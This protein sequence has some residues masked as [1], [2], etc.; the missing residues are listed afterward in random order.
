[1][2]GDGVVV[3]LHDPFLSP[4]ITRDAAGRWL[5]GKG[6]PVRSLTLAQLQAHD[7]GRIDPD[8]PYARTFPTQRLRRHGAADRLGGGRADHR[9][10]DRLRAVLAGRGMPLPPPVPVR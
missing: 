2:T 10:S 6:P 7:V 8:A 9:P 1:V 4:A 5:P 3:V